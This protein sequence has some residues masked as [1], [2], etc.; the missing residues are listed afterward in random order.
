MKGIIYKEQLNI[1]VF[2]LL[3]YDAKMSTALEIMKKL[4]K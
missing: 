3:L 1:S 2:Q 4:L